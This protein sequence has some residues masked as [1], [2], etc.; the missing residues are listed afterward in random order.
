MAEGI[1]IGLGPSPVL[2]GDGAEAEG[3]PGVAVEDAPD[4]DLFENTTER[5]AME[6]WAKGRQW[7]EKFVEGTDALSTRQFRRF[8]ATIARLE[9]PS[10][11]NTTRS[12]IAVEALGKDLQ[13][14][15]PTVGGH[16][17]VATITLRDGFTWVRHQ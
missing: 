17:D 2:S 5:D 11:I 9:M 8:M 1:N 14:Y 10:L 7:G 16:I 6:E 15:P 4:P 13:G 12:L 3:N